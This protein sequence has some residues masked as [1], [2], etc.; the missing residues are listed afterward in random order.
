M[1]PKKL[2]SNIDVTRGSTTAGGNTK[3]LDAY[4]KHTAAIDAK[5]ESM[6]MKLNADSPY[7]SRTA[8]GISRL[9]N[10][11]TERDRQNGVR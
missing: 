1:Q 9:E 7:L 5:A 11:K 8:P 10:S 2:E 4:L 6:T 3:R